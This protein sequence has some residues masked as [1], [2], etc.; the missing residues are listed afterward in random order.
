MA[1]HTGI[2]TRHGTGLETYCQPEIITMTVGM[3]EWLV[4]PCTIGEVGD[5]KNVKELIEH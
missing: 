3:V 2:D 1:V 5:V 4:V